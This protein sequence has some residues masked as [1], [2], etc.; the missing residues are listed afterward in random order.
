MERYA[1]MRL[2]ANP[3]VERREAVY[4]RLSA[5]RVD[6]SRISQLNGM[7]GIRHVSTREV[8]E[9]EAREGAS[10]DALSF[11]LLPLVLRLLPD[12]D[13][14]KAM[15]SYGNATNWVENLGLSSEEEQVLRQG[16]VRGIFDF[17]AFCLA[18]DGF[19]EGT[20]FEIVRQV[21]ERTYSYPARYDASVLGKFGPSTTME[22]HQLI[23]PP[24]DEDLVER[25]I[26]YTHRVL[27]IV[28]GLTS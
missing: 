1:Q 6:L 7:I 27:S 16:F 25:A 22:V 4:Q 28:E 18:A 15:S 9:Q 20:T 5:H 2:L 19:G 24:Q 23:E 3:S 10:G 26:Y 17:V 11:S 8:A 12:A 21:S 13:K 14:A